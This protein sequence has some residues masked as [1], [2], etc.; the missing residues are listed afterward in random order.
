MSEPREFW[1]P[2][3]TNNDPTHIARHED[4]GKERNEKIFP[5]FIH[6]IE[7]SAYDDLKSEYDNV[8]K[9]ANDYERQRDDL[10]ADLEQAR[11]NW[12]EA[13]RRLHDKFAAALV[14]RD[15]LKFL[16]EQAN[17]LLK[18]A[19]CLVD[20]GASYRAKLKAM[21]TLFECDPLSCTGSMIRLLQEARQALAKE[22]K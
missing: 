10:K 2:T 8:C 20:M 22:E 6:V 5:N 7:M 14:E 15:Q 1:I 12:G 17:C 18:D 21:I 9:F 16:V 13:E 11:I 19:D 4:P 3:K